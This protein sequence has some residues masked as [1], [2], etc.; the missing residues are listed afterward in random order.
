MYPVQFRLYLQIQIKTSP[1]RE[2]R[3]GEYIK[4]C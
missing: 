1:F 3:D 4:E 2:E